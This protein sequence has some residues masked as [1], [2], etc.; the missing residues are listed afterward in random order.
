M[1]IKKEKSNF[2]PEQ[3][4]LYDKLIA[5]N[6]AV[7][8]KGATVPYTSCNGHMFSQ[9]TEDGSLALRLPE[10]EMGHFLK[11]YNTGNH[12][13]YGI[14]RKEYAIVPDELF[15]KTKELKKYFDISYEYVKALK[16]KPTKKAKK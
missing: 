5:T 14:T 3:L 6:P 8:R 7:E 11:K 12:V 1:A 15:K 13:A 9:F 2:S 16:P 10:S 4:A